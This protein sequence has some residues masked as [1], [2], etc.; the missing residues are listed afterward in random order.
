MSQLI[1]V[2][3]G[4]Q[5]AE[6]RSKFISMELL[7][8]CHA[9]PAPDSGRSRRPIEG[10][11]GL[12][13][14][15]TVGDG[16]CRGIHKLGGDLYVVSGQEAFRVQ[17][18]PGGYT[19]TLVG[20][21]AGK[22]PVD[23]V[24]NATQVA[25]LTD[26]FAYS[27]NAAGVVTLPESN[28]VGA[29]YQDGY[30]TF[31][32]RDTENWFI[33]A[34][35]D[36][37]SIAAVDFTN[38]D[39]LPDNLVGMISDHGEVGAFGEDTIEWYQNTGNRAFPFERTQRVETGCAAGGSIAKEDNSVFWLG[40][41]LQVY[42]AEAYRPRVISTPAVNFAIGQDSTPDTAR[43]FIYSQEGHKHY[44]LMMTSATLVLNI[45]TGL[46]HKR[47]S[48][49]ETRWRAQGYA[50]QWGKHI[51]GDFE[52]SQISELDLDTYDENGNVLRRRLHSPTL[53]NQGHRVITDEIYVDME[54]GVGLDGGV[55]GADPQLM[56]Q[57]TDDSG[58]TWK[59]ERWRSSGKQGEYTHRA[60]WHRCGA[61]RSRIY[62]IE[63]SD[64]VEFRML[65]VFAR[66]E[67]LAA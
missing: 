23:M 58:H 59:N 29:G 9:V 45:T 38:A 34:I 28:L 17:R 54:A 67:R 21:I 46:W 55:Q 1:P 37:T 57:W 61:A 13:S 30:G 12:L 27:I 25:V 7:E 65:S 36:F 40:H 42:V 52:T 19:T 16:P 31:A 62:K 11:P 15:F 63:H 56:L 48:D 66:I 14:L 6:G 2:D 18:T 22:R 20:I 26:T 4:K 41:D 33:T 44:V 49:G 51:V 43:A 60:R 5:F 39:T 8:N 53:F 35:D 32:K 50:K 10:T 64:P 24:A 47:V 3:F